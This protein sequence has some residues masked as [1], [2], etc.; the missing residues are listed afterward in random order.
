MLQIVIFWLK[1]ILS[2][3]GNVLDQTWN[4]FDYK[5]GPQSK[6]KESSYQERQILK[7]FCKSV[8]FTLVG[9]KLCKTVL[10]VLQIVKT[11][12]FGGTWGEL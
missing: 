2:F 8:T 5:F 9:F 6:V 1:S 7:L 12:N 10:T 11:F 4:A 3:L